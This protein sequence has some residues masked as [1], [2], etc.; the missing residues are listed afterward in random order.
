MPALM[1]FS[2]C[3]H[4]YE[5]MVN[6]DGSTVTANGQAYPQG[7]WEIE[8]S[9]FQTE[10][11]PGES[12]KWELTYTQTGKKLEKLLSGVEETA[13]VLAARRMAD[14]DG[15][16]KDQDAYFMSTYLTPSGLPVEGFQYFIANSHVG[17]PYKT[18]LDYFQTID[19]ENIQIDKDRLLI[20]T[21]IET[22]LDDDFPA[23]LYRIE[24]AVYAKINQIWVQLHSI[25]A[26]DELVYGCDLDYEYVFYTKTL[27]P[28]MKIGKI[29]PPRAIWTLFASMA[30]F[31]VA[32]SVALEDKPYFAMTNRVKPQTRYTLPCTPDRRKC[33]YQIEPD[34][35]TANH[36]RIFSTKAYNYSQLEPDYSKGEVTVRVKRPDG[37]TDDLGTH[38]FRFAG[39]TGQKTGSGD[40]KYEFD[41]FGKYEITMTGQTVDRFGNS[42][43]GGGTYE[44]W[45]A[46]P[47][48]FATG[49]KPCTNITV[50]SFYSPAASINPGLPAD[51]TAT[52]K[53][54]PATHPE[55][56]VEVVYE[57]TAQKF[58]YFFP[59][60]SQ[61]LYRFPEPGEYLFD[62]LATYTDP[63]GRVFMGNMRNASIVTPGEFSLEV[64]GSP[65]GSYDRGKAVSNA[66][67][68]RFT[69]NQATIHFPEKTGGM[70]YFYGN[71]SN[72]QLIQPAVSVDEKTGQ[73]QEILDQN[74]PEMLINIATESADI[75]GTSF[76]G[77]QEQMRHFKDNKAS[78][79]FLP[80][81]STTSKGY[82]PFEYPEL[83]NRRGYFY[84][85]S[86]RPGFPVY[87]TVAD[88]TIAE[89][90]WG[91]SLNDYSGTIGAANNGDQPGDVYWSL[92]AGFFADHQAQKAFSG[93]YSNGGLALPLGENISTYRG[94]AFERPIATI[95][96]I[97]LDFYAGVGPSPGTL[98]ETGAV[99]GVGSI[100]VP[101]VPHDVKIVIHKPDGSVH[102]CEGRADQIGNFV[103]PSGPLHLEQPGVYKV[104]TEFTEGEFSGNCVGS[105]AGWY[106]IYAVKKQS[107]Y[108]VLF[109]ASIQRPLDY[110]QPRE[111]SG[112]IDPPV[113]SG[114]VHYSVVAPGILIDEGENELKDGR[115]SFR[116]YPR[117]IGAQFT[118]L[119]EH[120]LGMQNLIRGRSI[121]LRNSLKTLFFGFEEKKLSDTI[122]FVVFFE[123]EDP[124]GQP[125]TA[126]GKFVLRG[127]RVI[128]PMGS[129]NKKG[130]RKR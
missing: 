75:N 100:T 98:Y 104:F 85:A 62:I 127:E 108:S 120:L 24:L 109:D 129:I 83:T 72:Y 54:F 11:T 114:R 50:G 9:N 19:P 115:F 119:H 64:K 51:V 38:A 66:L 103:C 95:N 7:E 5:E 23:G 29:K 10:M 14:Q 107:P 33:T 117:Q 3:F 61:P 101:M 20:K 89:N 46:Y 41:Q 74:F 30:N 15:H 130:Q 128:V 118:N 28:P 126:G 56:V 116:F 122:E 111:I 69:N 16:Y 70:V 71:G 105:R 43:D 45:V 17:G 1:L 87:F 90:Y 57:G 26:F 39:L 125:A 106:K 110:D 96:G 58:G 80:L 123:G 13:V 78:G 8:V 77:C 40:L 55:D 82:S 124:K 53:F 37:R 49:I 99:K 59:D 25:G 36:Q 67:D 84:I 86:S 18:P 6:L 44:V 48:T 27:L 73:L 79:T 76:P 112:I 34:L 65:E 60:K 12:I 92:V 32:G 102:E 4:D 93:M 81:M 94:P 97:E 63:S 2:G 91:T 121:S 35:P 88:S 42:F 21:Q 31:G 68:G 47:L 52:V 113:K 22:K